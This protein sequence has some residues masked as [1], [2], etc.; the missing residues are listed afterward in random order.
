[1]TPTTLAVLL[2]L[3]LGVA[4]L[5]GPWMLRVAAPALVRVPR[6]AIGLL[7]GILV[8]WLGA[9][10]AIGPVLAWVVTGP[11]VLPGR[12]GQACQQCLDAANPFASGTVETGV[13]VVLLL[14]APALVAGLLAVGL[15]R[16][17]RR[18][19]VEARRAAEQLLARAVPRRVLGQDVL[20][21]PDERPLALALPVRHG[22]IVVSQGTLTCLRETELAAVLAHER[23]H[24]RQRH[25]LIIGLVASLARHLRWVPLVAAI[26]AAL[27][28][29][30]EIAADN[31]ARRTAGT[32][33]LVSALLRL[34][35]RSTPVLPGSVGALHMAGPE[36][37]RH[38]V[39]PD[40]GST[41]TLPALAVVT[42]L[43]ILAAVGAAVHLPYAVAALHGC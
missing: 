9:A 16:E 36:R 28:H 4:A 13:P 3:A 33:A 17:C 2:A 24:L 29:Y 34:G 41:G 25:H 35:E 15:G 38:L 11:A 5:W 30:L 27:P 23:A 21:V 18:R 39:L 32:S 8:A 14:A 10:L 12:A 20:V 37:I 22:G 40:R 43:V 19:G 31:Q 1:M 26:D 7:L 6:L 42:H